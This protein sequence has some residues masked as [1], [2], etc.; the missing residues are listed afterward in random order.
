MGVIPKLFQ[1]DPVLAT[2]RSGKIYL[3][4]IDEGRITDA[5]YGIKRQVYT[6]NVEPDLIKSE[7]R[8]LDRYDYEY[9]AGQRG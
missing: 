9:R 8:R 7:N 5:F 6:G 4:M 2:L 3:K 1:G